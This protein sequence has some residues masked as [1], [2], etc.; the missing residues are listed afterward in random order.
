MLLIRRAPCGQRLI[1]AVIEPDRVWV[2]FHALAFARHKTVPSKIQAQLNA[3]W[4]KACAPV[5]FTLRKK[6][7]PLDAVTRAVKTAEER[8]PALADIA[9]RVR[10]GERRGGTTKVFGWCSGFQD[11]RNLLGA[12]ELLFPRGDFFEQVG[13]PLHGNHDALG[14]LV[15]LRGNAQPLLAVGNVVHHAGLGTDGHLVA[16]F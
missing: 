2:K 6:I 8:L 7:V 15:R 12:A 4:M 13:Q 3:A 11:E 9:P 5:K 16:N 10:L 1:L 14:L